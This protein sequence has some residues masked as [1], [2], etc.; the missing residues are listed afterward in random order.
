MKWMNWFSICLALLALCAV[1]A[2]PVLATN[3]QSVVEVNGDSGTGYIPTQWTGQT[4][5]V[6]TAGKPY[7][8]SAVGDPVTVPYFVVSGT[9][10][11]PPVKPSAYTDRNHSWASGGNFF[12]IN[13]PAMPSYLVGGEYIMPPQGLRDNLTLRLDVTIASPATVYL[14]IDNRLGEAVQGGNGFPLDPPTFDADFDTVPDHMAWVINDGWLPVKNGIN[15]LADVT[16]PDEVTMDESQDAATSG[17]PANGNFD[18]VFSVY[19][20]RFPA[21]TFS[22]YQANKDAG[23]LNM[24]GV[25]ITPEPTTA[26]LLLLSA[27]VGSL[28]VRRKRQ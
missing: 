3:I 14:L 22:L 28:T 23:N 6:T 26:M 7:T 13:Y 9:P 25:V 27:T 12:G 8:A 5:T 18:S 10:T 2:T 21:G 20:K 11:S 17:N 1:S 15:H 24:Y 19:S 16:I 4:F